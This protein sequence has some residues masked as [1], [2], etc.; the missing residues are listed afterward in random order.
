MSDAYHSC[1]VLSGLSAAQHQWELDEPEP[2]P[3]PDSEPG[4][5][6]ASAQATAAAAAGSEAVWAVLPCLDGLQVFDNKDR[7]R[8]IHPVY[9]IPQACV[10]EMKG[11]FEGVQGF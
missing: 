10:R 9:A 11:Y 4:A 3:A 5:A 7:V 2:A 8:P 1:Y 6:A